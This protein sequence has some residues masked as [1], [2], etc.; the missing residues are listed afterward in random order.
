MDGLTYIIDI[1]I[2]KI[3]LM[4]EFD[5]LYSNCVKIASF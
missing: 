3:F 4:K 5:I 1:H 2:N